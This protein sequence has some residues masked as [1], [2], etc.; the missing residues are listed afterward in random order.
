MKKRSSRIGLRP[1]F[2]S[3]LQRVRHT[4]AFLLAFCM[5]SYGF[6]PLFVAGQITVT[7]SIHPNA[8]EIDNSANLTAGSGNANI[9]NTGATLDWIKD[10]LANTDTPSLIDSIATG[11]KTTV[12]NQTGATGGTGHW[13]GVRIVDG[14]GGGDQDIFLKGGKVNDSASWDIG[15][16]TVGSSKFD[17]TQMY[18]ANNQ[19]NIFFG[20]ERNGNNGTTAF[21]F[22]FNQ[23]PPLSA[24]IPD[25]SDGDLL[26][27][28]ELQGSGG[29]SGSVLTYLFE[30]NGTTD[31]YE[32]LCDDDPGTAGTGQGAC[33]AGLFTSINGINPTPAEPWGHVDGGSWIINPGFALRMFAEAQVPLSLLPGVNTCG[34]SGFVQIRTRASSALGSDAKD[35]TKIFEYSFGGPTAVGAL[36]SGCGLD[37]N[38]DATGSTTVG[39]GTPTYDWFFQ[40]LVEGNWVDVNGAGAD[41]TGVSGTFVAPGAG[42][43]RAVLRVTEATACFD[44]ETTNSVIVYPVVGGSASLTGDCD[45]TFTYTAQGT[46]GS[47]SYAYEWKFYKENGTTDIL[48]GTSSSQSGT[49]DIDTVTTP[50]GDGEYY[51]TVRI[52]DAN[53]TACFYDVTTN[54]I[55]VRHPLTVSIAK[56]I[57]S[58]LTSSAMLDSGFSVP[59]AATLGNQGSDTITKQWQQFTGNPADWAN[60]GSDSLTLTRTMAEIISAGT[61]GSAE[62]AT[63]LGDSYLLRRSSLQVRVTVS[64]T[65]NGTSC[66]V[67]S[68]PL[69][70]KAL[71]A[72][73]P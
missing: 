3:K 40:K 57:N 15:P 2:W 53:N 59:V 33:P 38:Y 7:G 10:S 49:I 20:M 43:Y 73:D 60:V 32:P 13:N 6:L 71:K 31:L 56:T 26:V 17:A 72:I 35:T 1:L 34:G 45:D 63:I 18:I 47:G 25:R 14:F 9:K 52:R 64:R 62:S 37:I 41:A 66:P 27:S 16:G 24:Y 50:S 51:A 65:L 12:P 61:T 19:T 39:G 28:F 11:I 44:D 23:L 68:D 21:D 70:V 58:I 30:Y 67:T 22:E 4:C 55:Q 54:A 8:I 36:T 5:L 69:T 29:S 48:V 46:G 42:T